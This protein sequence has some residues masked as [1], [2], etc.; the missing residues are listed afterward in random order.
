MGSKSSTLSGEPWRVMPTIEETQDF[1]GTRDF[2][3]VKHLRI[4]LHG[5]AGVGKTSFINSVSTALQGKISTLALTD[6][7]TAG[8][9][10]KQYKSYK[11][12]CGPGS[13]YSLSFTDVM[14]FE[15]NKGNGV[16]V[17]DLILALKGHI[18]EGYKFSPNH[19]ITEDSQWY[20]KS[21]T[22]AD[23]IHVLVSVFSADTASMLSEQVL[24]KLKDVRLEASQLGIPQLTI[25]TKVDQACPEV[26]KNIRN[27]HSSKYLKE[28]V[29]QINVQLGLQ[30][31]CIFLVKNYESEINTDPEVDAPILCA[32]KQMIS[33]GED[34]LN[35]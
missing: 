18:K 31:N 16:N 21:P 33:Y 23:R 17:K 6:A 28:K 27:I 9:F 35:M 13:N 25:L 26:Q 14:G 1:V 20:K 11:I 22:K 19:P 4:L 5:H 24:K 12:P 3:D 29:D 34:F 30:R 15:Q 8:S 10:T 2:E 7:A 32:L